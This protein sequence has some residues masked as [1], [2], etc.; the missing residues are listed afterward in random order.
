MTSNSALA[1]SN[2]AGQAA[3]NKALAEIHTGTAHP[4]KL[5]DAAALLHDNLEALRAFL[6][7][8]QKAIEREGN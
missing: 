1:A 6:R 4:G 2:I 8:V 3:A 5:F 7:V